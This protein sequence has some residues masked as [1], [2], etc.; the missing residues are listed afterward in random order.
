MIETIDVYKIGQYPAN[1]KQTSMKRDWMDSTYDSHAYRCFPVSL[2]NTIGYEIS[3][4]EDISFI[5][6]GIS[7][8]T[9]DHVKIISGHKYV[10]TG[11]SNAT[12][13]FSTSLI[14]KTSSNITM[15]HMPVPNFFVDGAQAFTGLISTSF[16]EDPMPAAWKITRA[17][18]V[19]TIKANQP[20]VTIVP[21]PLKQI[22]S[23]EMNIYSGEFSKDHDIMKE[24]SGKLAKAITQTG[25]WTNWYR[26]ATNYKNESIG[27]HEIKSIKLKI[28]DYSEEGRKIIS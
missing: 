5:W 15:M 14:F 10:G 9:P 28:N 4:P 7:D 24:E 12:I 23:L 13:S 25:H 17:N 19:I 27:A 26:N 1:I 11:R 8:S 21:I 16:Y 6:D 20:V 22:S 2:A 3:F 18:E